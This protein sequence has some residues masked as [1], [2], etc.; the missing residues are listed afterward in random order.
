MY[1]QCP[2]KE[3]GSICF[4]P[5]CPACLNELLDTE[6]GQI[7]DLEEFFLGPDPRKT[8]YYKDNQRI[9]GSI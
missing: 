5:E 7:D 1:L 6:L 2:F 3:Q 4:D 8:K 9:H